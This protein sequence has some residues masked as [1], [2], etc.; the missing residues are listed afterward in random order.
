[1][2]YKKYILH[3]MCSSTYYRH[4]RIIT[5]VRLYT[6]PPFP[7]YHRKG[8]DT[9]QM[10]RIRKRLKSVT[11]VAHARHDHGEARFISRLDDFIV[12]HRAA[13]LNDR[14]SARFSG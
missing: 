8:R 4:I 9:F 11:E 6:Y 3:C 2:F 12:A 1:M 7:I 10:W 5:I 13:W 14:C